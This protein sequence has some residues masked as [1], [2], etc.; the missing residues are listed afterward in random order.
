MTAEP[1]SALPAAGAPPRLLTLRLSIMMFLQWGMFGMWIPLA[2]VFI[3][4]DVEEGGL[5]FS[6]AQ[7]GWI[8]GISGSIGAL[9]AP[10]IAG[11]IA[12]RYFSTE[13]V[14]AVL[15]ILGGALWW[16]MSEQQASP[17]LPALS[18]V[19]PGGH[20][21]GA[22]LALSITAM[23]ALAPTGALSN[24]LA[25][26]H[27]RDRTRQFPVV[28]V[29]GTIGWIVAGW[30]FSWFWLQ[31]D[32]HLRWLP[33]FLVGQK[34]PDVTARMLDSLKAAAL[35]AWVYAAY[36]LTLPNTPPKREAAEKLAFW[37]AFRLFGRPSFLVLMV[38]AL[39]IACIHNI[40][41]MQTSPLLVH[42][43]LSKPL[44]GPAM[45]V[46]QI[47]EIVMIAILGLLLKR[48]GVRA[49]LTLGGAAY[50]LRFLFLGSTWLP[51]WAIV[52]SLGLHGVCFACYYAAAFIYVDRLADEDIRHT[53][54]TLFGILIGVG[55][56]IG[57]WLNGFLAG[58][59]TPEGGELN[60]AKFW[61][62]VAAIGGLAT[63]VLGLLFRDETREDQPGGAPAEGEAP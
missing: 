54:Q 60:Y 2:G 17:L 34:Y 55:P 1:P 44:V 51:L 8:L 41:F 40:F 24:S 10:F 53:A 38:A 48:L 63:L 5:G 3:L 4:A 59:F 31:H 11:Q 30:G 22:W 32:L 50:L 36:C 19:P 21:F 43:G 14:M 27:L 23:F 18:F 9:A 29:W 58:L 7:L 35:V 46:G 62:T 6:Q 42:L 20:R 47:T 12:D 33:P 45:S 16:T 13:R 57:G 25:F 26:S 39:L 15:L 49:V 37:K 56:V 52:A 61:Y 28:R